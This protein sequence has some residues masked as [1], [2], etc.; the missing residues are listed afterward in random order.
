M[1]RKPA[2]PAFSQMERGTT[3]SSSHLAWNGFTSLSRNFTNESRNALRFSSYIDSCMVFSSSDRSDRLRV[4]LLAALCLLDEK[5][6]GLE[7]LAELRREP[8]EGAHD[9]G[10]AR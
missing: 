4:E 7:A 9:G 1:Q 5:V 10:R 8:L 3:P 2:S 6:G